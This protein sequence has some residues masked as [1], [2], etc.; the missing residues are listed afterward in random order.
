LLCYLA[1]LQHYIPDRIVPK[2][3]VHF[4]TITGE[5]REA[6][7]SMPDCLHQSHFLPR[8]NMAAR[9]VQ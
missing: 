7:A 2:T 4:S 3:P 6:A 5:E 8:R 9:A 1:E